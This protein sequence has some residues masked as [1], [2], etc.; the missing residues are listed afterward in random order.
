MMD[1]HLTRMLHANKT[2][3]VYREYSNVER[4]IEY[5]KQLSYL[6]SQGRQLIQE[7]ECQK[8]YK[9][10]QFLGAV[11]TVYHFLQTL[12]KPSPL[13]SCMIYYLDELLFY[14]VS[15]RDS[16]IIEDDEYPLS[17]VYF[18][19][20]AWHNM[21]V[22]TY[23]LD[24]KHYFDEL[25]A[26]LLSCF[27]DEYELFVLELEKDLKNFKLNFTNKLRNNLQKL[28]RHFIYLKLQLLKV[29]EHNI[30]KKID[31]T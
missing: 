26:M 9:N 5:A 10:K 1:Q 21:P 30:S 22:K 19:T 27:I 2:M 24:K 25:E 7:I 4:H 14:E 16:F 17:Y 8:P 6:N 28:K 20:S 15:S 29:I 11:H 31:S 12:L 3:D 18:N 23:V 13:Y